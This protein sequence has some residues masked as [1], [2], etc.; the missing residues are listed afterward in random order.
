LECFWPEYGTVVFPRLKNGRV[1]ELCK[2][3]QEEF[4]TSIVP[5][6]FFENPDRF[7][8]GAGIPTEQVRD[9]LQQFSRGLDRYKESVHV[10][11]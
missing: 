9:A 3:L 4:E 7:R 6:R 5:G 8:M 11:T 10:S 2:L 1:E